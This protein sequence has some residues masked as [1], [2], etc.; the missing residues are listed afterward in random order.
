MND[1]SHIKQL[2]QVVEL[3][4][5]MIISESS[6]LINSLDRSI[7]HPLNGKFRNFPITN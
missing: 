2:M 6:H 3:N 7:N 4:L 5:N 1:E